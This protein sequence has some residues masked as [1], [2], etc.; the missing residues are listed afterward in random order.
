MAPSG[1][2]LHEPDDSDQAGP[3]LSSPAGKSAAAS[4]RSRNTTYACRRRKSLL[5]WWKRSMVGRVFLGRYETIRVL[6][7]GGMGRV[8]L[9][10]QTDLGRQV[11][12]KVM[13]DHIA[14]DP[15]FR[16]R[17]ARETLLMA[18]FTHP[19]AV[20]LYDASLNDPQGPCIVMEYIRGISLDALLRSDNKLEPVRVGRLLGQLCEVLQ[21]AHAEGIIHRDLKPA[22]LMIV[23]PGTAYEILKVMDF[24]LAKL[25]DPDP[26]VR[27]ASVTNTEFAVGTPGYMCPEQAR[28]EDMDGRGD[29]Y[30]VG[31]IL[32]E[33]LTGRLPF[34]GRST[35]DMLLA[36]ATE[37][38]P[39]FAQSG[40]RSLPIAIEHVVQSCLTKD[41]KDRPASARELHERYQAALANATGPTGTIAEFKPP[42]PSPRLAA[43]VRLA[44]PAPPPALAGPV[45][46]PTQA[47]VQTPRDYDPLAIIHHMDAWMPERIAAY[48]L[49]GFIGDVGGDVIESVPG[50]IKVR[51][52]GKG[53]VYS[54]PTRGTLAWLGLNRR[55][56]QIDMELRLV[57]ADTS[58]DNHLRITVLL[59]P[60]IGDL[61]ADEEWQK[62]CRQIFCDLRAYLMGQTN[63]VSAG[64]AV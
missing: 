25:L 62:L 13:H 18:R 40:A 56:G 45:P 27:L 24:G 30:S 35:M 9:A 54:A 55:A 41:P 7:E 42:P 53:S 28:G 51:L 5:A 17:F 58:R 48:K 36:H 2:I 15:K 14:A 23:D 4:A 16:E 20:T 52:G 19:F 34:S 49:T 6:G 12:V 50:R 43:P 61:S 31:V 22:N 63:I 64:A 1:T 11:V 37:E 21:A 38:P 32:Y 44:P 46:A 10:K 26:M 39:S 59:R 47:P 3:G 33:M 29:L 57:R 60:T 8:Y